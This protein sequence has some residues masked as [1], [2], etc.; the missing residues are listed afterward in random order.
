[1]QPFNS[2]IIIVVSDLRSY[3]INICMCMQ[4]WVCRTTAHGPNV[5]ITAWHRVLV[6]TSTWHKT[7][8][9]IFINIWLS[10]IKFVNFACQKKK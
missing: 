7:E 6:Q 9:G 8:V 5:S 3:K 1:M 10:L 4:S 2:V